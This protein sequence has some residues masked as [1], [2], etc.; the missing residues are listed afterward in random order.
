ML[1][2][3]DPELKE[4]GGKGGSAARRKSP[5][6]KSGGKGEAKAKAKPKAKPAAKAKQ[7]KSWGHDGG[8]P[9]EELEV[10]TEVS[11][12]VTNRGSFGVFL[13]FGAVKDGKLRLKKDEWRKFR[14]GDEVEEMVIE[15]VDLSNGQIS[16]ALTYELGDEPEELI[17]EAPRQPKAKAR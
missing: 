17:E 3:E 7:A 10:G 14:K 13:D 6:A 4:P 12:V 2:L 8:M 1:S 11:G 15:N 9:L 5:E 16:L